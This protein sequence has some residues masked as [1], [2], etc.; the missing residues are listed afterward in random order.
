MEK[1][2]LLQTLEEAFS[3]HNI[4]TFA[5]RNKALEMDL[6]PLFKRFLLQPG[7][8]KSLQNLLLFH[9]IPNSIE[10]T[11]WPTEVNKPKNHNSLCRDSNGETL[12]VVEKNGE[13][14]VGMEK[15][16]KPDDI[17]RPD[18]IIHS[19]ERVLI[20]KSVQQDF[21]MCRSLR[22]ISAVILEGA[23]EVDPRTQTKETSF[24][25]IR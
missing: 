18:R 8:L 24:A 25:G 15:I 19:N 4:T 10:S 3:K 23:P 2:L 21:N 1:A 17:T 11:R 14:L 13:I 20:P 22:S 7:N 12:Q 9:M 5:P 6:D 16:I